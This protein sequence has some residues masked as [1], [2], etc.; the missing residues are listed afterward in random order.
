MQREIGT[1]AEEQVRETGG[2]R[3][4]DIE[5]DPEAGPQA[6]V[7]ERGGAPS[8]ADVAERESRNMGIVDGV[9]RMEDHMEDLWR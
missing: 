9:D 8:R 4:G 1:E 5:R 7:A 2:G 3:G 6:R